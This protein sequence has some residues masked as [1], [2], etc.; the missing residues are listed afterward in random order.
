M[1]VC[2]AILVPLTSV[3]IAPQAAFAA[4]PQSVSV[5]STVGTDRVVTLKISCAAASTCRGK[6]ALSLSTGGKKTLDYAVAKWSSKTLNWKI[7]TT[8]YRAFTAKK[9]AK[10]TLAGTATKP[11]KTKFSKKATLKVAP[12]RVSVTQKT[13]EIAENGRLPLAVSCGISTG[14][15][16]NV[17]LQFS[18]TRIVQKNVTL[19]KGAHTVQLTI[20]AAKLPEI[21]TSTGAQRVVIAETKP[22]AVSRT[23][24]VQLTRAIPEPPE[25]TAST[26]YATRNWTP[27][28][29]D[30]CPAELHAQ[31]TTVGPDGKLYPT[32][33]PAQVTDPATGALCAFGHEH[34]ADPT[35]SEIYDWA[36]DFFAP[37][38]YVAG[39]ARGLPFGYV[40]EELDAFVHEHGNMSMRHE[41]NAGHKVFVANNVKMLDANRN[42]LTLADGSQLTC[43]VLIKMHQGSWSADATS[44]NAHEMLFAAQCND[45]TKLITSLLTRFGNANEMFDSCAP[46]TPIP[47]VGSTLPAGDGGKRIIPSYDCVR[48]NPR[49][50][51]LYEVWESDTKI[52]AQDGSTLAFLDPWFGIRNPSRMYDAR[53]STAQANGISRPLDLAWLDPNPATDYLWAG[54]AAQE[55]FDYRDPRSPF[56]GAQRDFYLGQ[57]KAQSTGTEGGIVYTDPYG[58]AARPDPVVGSVRQLI[59]PGSVLGS[60]DLAQQK[61]DSKADFGKNNGVHAPN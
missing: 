50:W 20:P 53:S 55:R 15:T 58:G 24:A 42:W 35:T 30:T 10:L 1:A 54:L 45:G 39:E 51:T 3:I 7:S 13:Y 9:Q 44:N 17:Q 27:T 28:E 56:D 32:W 59:T 47:T 34:G 16:A 40:S 60:V 57:L 26:A 12:A 33:H 36:A 21:D 43:D 61:F 41:D 23:T 52:V 19:A 14:C 5:T 25:R 49:D 31:F 18:G 6:V 11:S 37:E 46:D 48:N 2:C 4:S 22:D 38:D 29:F 8:A